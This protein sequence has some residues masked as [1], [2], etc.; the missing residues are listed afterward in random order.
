MGG[1][2][3]GGAIEIFFKFYIKIIYLFLY[4]SKS[5]KLYITNTNIVLCTQR[6][7][8]DQKVRGARHMLPLSI[9]SAKTITL[10]DAVLKPI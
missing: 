2:A 1:G 7:S 4:I 10:L 5:L 9:K 8:V 3:R 6:C